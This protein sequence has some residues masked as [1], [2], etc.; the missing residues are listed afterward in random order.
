MVE[1]RCM[2]IKFNQELGY[3]PRK[4]Q[5]SGSSGGKLSGRDSFDTLKPNMPNPYFPLQQM[6]GDSSADPIYTRLLVE[7]IDH[8]L[9]VFSGILQYNSGALH[10]NYLPGMWWLKGLSASLTLMA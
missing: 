7:F 5:I 2:S 10:A 9:A 4:E 3:C 6:L 8:F 1:K